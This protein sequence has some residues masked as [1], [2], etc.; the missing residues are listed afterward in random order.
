M[1]ENKNNELIELEKEKLKLEIRNLRYSRLRLVVIQAIITVITA[2]S[3]LGITWFFNREYISLSLD[4]KRLKSEKDNI[5]IELRKDSL[6]LLAQ[7]YL[8]SAM[9]LKKQVEIRELMSRSG[10]VSEMGMIESRLFFDFNKAI[11]KYN[12]TKNPNYLTSVFVTNIGLIENISFRYS[13]YSAGEQRK[14]TLNHIWEN[15]IVL[16]KKIVSGLQTFGKIQPKTSQDTI[17]KYIVTYK[18]LYNQHYAMIRNFFIND[19][20]GELEILEMSTKN[21]NNSPVGNK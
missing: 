21:K 13:M 18:E 19:T 12:E 2:S 4:V 1:T 15:N 8:D 6:S 20:T 10:I 16:W 3:I 5:E 7:D 11:E 14:D 9:F 17:D